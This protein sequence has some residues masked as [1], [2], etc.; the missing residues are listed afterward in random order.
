MN[1][2]KLS[3]GSEVFFETSKNDEGAF[4]TQGFS[5]QVDTSLQK[6]SEIGGKVLKD[7]FEFVNNALDTIKP[8]ELEVEIGLSISYEGSIIITKGSAEANVT[9]KATWKPK[10]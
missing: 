5:D 4:G 9:I 3:D 1:K 7:T 6:V 10:E 8:N 2:V